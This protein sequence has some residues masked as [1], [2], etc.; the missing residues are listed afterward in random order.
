[1]DTLGNFLA[2][3]I[4]IF[5]PAAVLSMFICIYGIFEDRIID[6]YEQKIADRSTSPA[7]KKRNSSKKSVQ[8]KRRNVKEEF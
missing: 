3:M 7:D 2:D 1:M 8:Q 5:A 6:Y 4:I